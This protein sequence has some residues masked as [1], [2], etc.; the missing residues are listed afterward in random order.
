MTTTTFLVPDFNKNIPN[1]INQNVEVKSKNILSIK[2]APEYHSAIATN[3]F[4]PKKDGVFVYVTR[5]NN[6]GNGDVMVGF[7][8]MATY[9]ST[10][11]GFPG[12]EL[13]GTSFYCWGGKRYPGGA[14]YLPRNIKAEEIIS[15]LTISNN[16]AKKEVQWIV[17][18]N[19]GPVRD[20]T[21]DKD[22]FGNGA[23]IFPCIL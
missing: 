19:E 17:D 18:G 22:G 8:D 10:E 13:S 4:P 12:E 20:C 16:G 23:E 3:G 6:I 15:V 1:K 7:T 14:D 5:I 9:D 21:K 11:E 2:E